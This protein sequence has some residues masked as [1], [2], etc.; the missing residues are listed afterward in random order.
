MKHYE[1]N[2]WAIAL[3]MMLMSRR[4]SL[5]KKKNAYTRMDAVQFKVFLGCSFAVTVKNLTFLKQIVVFFQT[6]FLSNFMIWRLPSQIVVVR[7]CFGFVCMCWAFFFFL[8]GS[9]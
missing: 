8:I 1:I 2:I 5:A 6:I 3:K 9:Y 7:W 4:V